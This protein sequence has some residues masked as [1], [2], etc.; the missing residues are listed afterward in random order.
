M[1]KL[2]KDKKAVIFDMDGVIV[3]SNLYWEE[4]EQEVFTNLGVKITD[5]DRRSTQ[6]MKTDEATLY[7]YKK[8]P[9]KNFTVKEVEQKVISRV[10]NLIED[11]D[12]QI[13]GIKP[14]IQNL[15]QKGLSIALATNSPSQVISVVLKKTKTE[16]LFDIILSADQVTKGKPYPDIYLLA[17]RELGVHPNECLVVEDSTYGIQA[18]K[19]A[20]M[21][22]VGFANDGKNKIIEE[23]DYILNRF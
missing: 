13:E 5:E 4:A 3:D 11:N 14:F 10:I 21:T 16:G 15:K 23:V 6:A 7:W 8:S 19:N 1:E 20:K 2:L 17:A 12:S 18:A 9:W 22:V